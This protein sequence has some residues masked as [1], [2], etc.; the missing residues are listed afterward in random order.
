MVPQEFNAYGFDLAFQLACPDGPRE[1]ARGK[2]G[3]VFVDRASR[4]VAAVPPEF[5]ARLA[6]QGHV[7]PT[8]GS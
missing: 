7:A 1:V 6:A 3:I 2:V 8:A 5:M 4:K